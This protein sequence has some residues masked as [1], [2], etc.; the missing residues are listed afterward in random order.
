[1][2]GLLEIEL[3]NLLFH[4]QG[5]DPTCSNTEIEYLQDTNV[6]EV[7]STRQ[8]RHTEE[9]RCIVLREDFVVFQVKL[10]EVCDEVRV[11]VPPVI[12]SMPSERRISQ[13]QPRSSDLRIRRLS[14]RSGLPARPGRPRKKKDEVDS[15]ED[16]NDE[17]LNFVC[18]SCRTF[19]SIVHVRIRSTHIVHRDERSHQ[20]VT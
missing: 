20:S 8:V 12:A 11:M 15:D 17:D 7:L 4:A 9:R 1:M 3:L 6:W 14:V 5:E 18:C 2:N 19:V 16:L 13:Q 10:G